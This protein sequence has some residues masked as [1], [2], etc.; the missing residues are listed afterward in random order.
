MAAPVVVNR[1]LAGTAGTL[2]PHAV[3]LKEFGQI[4][5][6]LNVHD[7]ALKLR[8]INTSMTCAKLPWIQEVLRIPTF[9]SGPM[10]NATVGRQYDSLPS[11]DTRD[12]ASWQVAQKDLSRITTAF[13]V[14]TVTQAF[15]DGQHGIQIN[16]QMRCV[17]EGMAAEQYHLS[18]LPVMDKNR[19]IGNLAASDVSADVVFNADGS[20]YTDGSAI[21]YLLMDRSAT[22]VGSAHRAVRGARIEIRPATNPNVM[23]PEGPTTAVRLYGRIVEIHFGKTLGDSGSDAHA[24]GAQDYLAVTFLKE[25]WDKVATAGAYS[26]TD[27][28]QHNY[29]ESASFSGRL[30]D[31]ND[32]TTGPDSEPTFANVVNGDYILLLDG[33]ANGVT[34]IDEYSLNLANYSSAALLYGLDPTLPGMDW[35]HFRTMDAPS[36]TYLSPALLYS[37]LEMCNSYQDGS[38]LPKTLRVAPCQGRRLMVLADLGQHLIR[39][40]NPTQDKAIAQIGYTGKVLLYNDQTY[41]FHEDPTQLPHRI[42]LL[43]KASWQCH[44]VGEPG[45]M[46]GGIDGKW[47]NKRGTSGER[48]LVLQAHRIGFEL[49]MC[50]MPELNYELRGLAVP[51]YDYA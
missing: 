40:V 15:A 34:G 17:R 12:D 9:I 32:R 11:A 37:F 31:A 13:E 22:A 27:I 16:E 46:K 10:G 1:G 26:G 20:V 19:T 35:T 47:D 2:P 18:M 42:Q 8:K 49:V 45:W 21:V 43:D 14:N 4:L 38:D 33:Y 44:Q 3:D 29:T 28:T 51:D 5:T 25:D 30:P 24:L 50:V 36:S 7:R 48:T 41:M 39:Q 23:P 6:K